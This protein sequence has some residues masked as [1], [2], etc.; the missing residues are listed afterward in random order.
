M[1]LLFRGVGELIDF[2]WDYFVVVVVV[3]DQR[4]CCNVRGC[5]RWNT[6]GFGNVRHWLGGSKFWRDLI[7][8]VH[9][10]Q[11]VNVAHSAT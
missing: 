1:T 7:A 11:S 5:R 3:V 6:K 8:S 10:E 9:S 4:C 2:H